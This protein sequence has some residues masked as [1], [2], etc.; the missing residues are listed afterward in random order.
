MQKNFIFV[1]DSVEIKDSNKLSAYG[2]F[3]SVGAYGFPATQKEMA[4]VV[5][6]EVEENQ[7]NKSHTERFEIIYDGKYIIGRDTEF[8]PTSPRHQFLHKVENVLFPEEGKY[9]V[10]ISIDGKTIGESYFLVKQVEK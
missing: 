9:V 10:R 3:D 6:I 2:I 5:N 4:I 1:C 7:R 8:N